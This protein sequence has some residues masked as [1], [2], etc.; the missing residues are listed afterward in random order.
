MRRRIELPQVCS[1]PV[2][3]AGA[4]W[5]AVCQPRDPT[6]GAIPSVQSWEAA[7]A[8]LTLK[9]LALRAVVRR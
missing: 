1:Y 6:D 8:D 2:A 9:A 7:S 5:L 3:R 4:G